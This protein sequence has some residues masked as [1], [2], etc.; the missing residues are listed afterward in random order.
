VFHERP[1]KRREKC[2][3][4]KAP[5]PDPLPPSNAELAKEFTGWNN[6]VLPFKSELDMK[7]MVSWPLVPEAADSSRTSM[8]PMA[9]EERL[10]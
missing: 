2:K 5:K 4:L 10:T 8:E 1:Q 9:V 3:W 7:D 6:V